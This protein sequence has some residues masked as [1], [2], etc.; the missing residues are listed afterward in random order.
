MLYINLSEQEKQKLMSG[1][2]FIRSGENPY[3]TNLSTEDAE[4]GKN[5][6]KEWLSQQM[7]GQCSIDLPL[8][9]YSDTETERMKD[10][11]HPWTIYIKDDIRGVFVSRLAFE[12]LMDGHPV[13]PDDIE[14]YIV[15]NFFRQE[16]PDRVA[17]LKKIWKK[18]ITNKKEE[19]LK[20][21]WFITSE[22]VVKIERF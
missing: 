8:A 4:D 2:Y 15:D 1:L 17:E 12:N 3:K 21:T 5:W 19:Q 6:L 9:L 18:N 14:P 7:P 16:K 22:D 20:L 10:P 11:D 13:Y